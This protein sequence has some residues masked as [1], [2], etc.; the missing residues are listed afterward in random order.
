[1]LKDWVTCITTERLKLDKS[2]RRCQGWHM[3]LAKSL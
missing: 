2:R 3:R 1:V